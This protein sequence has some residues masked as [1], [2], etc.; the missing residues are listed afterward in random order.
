MSPRDNRDFSGGP[1]HLSEKDPFQHRVPHGARNRR[2]EG[3]VLQPET[4]LLEKSYA[5]SKETKEIT[6]KKT[7]PQQ[8]FPSTLKCGK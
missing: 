5:C 2:E 4:N 8:I 6:S 7:S 3:A 1:P